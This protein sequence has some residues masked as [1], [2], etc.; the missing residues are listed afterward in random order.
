LLLGH[1]LTNGSIKG[2]SVAE[3]GDFRDAARGTFSNMYFFGFPDPATD[4]RGDFS[5]SSGSDVTFG[6]GSLAFSGLQVTLPVGV[7][8]NAVFKAGTDVHATSV[9]AGANTVGANKT[10]FLTWTWAGVDGQ[11]SSF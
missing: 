11:L 8:L 2:S 7:A 1:T 10:S 4:G 6:D 5:L 3:L 9:A